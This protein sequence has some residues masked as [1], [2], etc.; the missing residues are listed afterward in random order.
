MLRALTASV[1]FSL[2]LAAPALAQQAEPVGEAW[3]LSVGEGLQ[4]SAD[5]RPSYLAGRPIV[6]TL[7]VD[8]AGEE[9]LEF[10]RLDERP[11]LVSFEL[12]SAAGKKQT[13][14]NAA[15]VEDDDL[16][17]SLP[18]RASR[19]VSL[20]L[21]SGGALAPGSYQL[22]IEVE[23]DEVHRL[24]PHALIIEAPRPVSADVTEAGASTLGWQVPWVHASDGHDLYLHTASAGDPSAR[25]YEWHLHGLD[26]PVQPLLAHGPGLE[27]AN[28]MIYWRD[29]ERS[30]AF[31]RLEERKLRHD[32]RTVTL[33]YPD[34][35]LLARAGADGQGGLQVPVWIPAPSGEA[36]E[37]RVVSID[38]R[39]QPRF[40]RVE[41]FDLAPVA[42]S[43]VDNAGRLRLLLHHDEKLDLYTV[44][45]TGELPA[46]G[47]RLLPQALR[48][49]EVHLLARPTPPE[50]SPA[51]GALVSDLIL[52][53]VD[54][55]LAAMTPPS[56]AGVRF[57]PLPERG[58]EAGGMA[59]FTW[60]GAT[61][62]GEMPGVWLSIKG[63][64]IDTVPG[65]AL[66]PGHVVVE[67]FPQGYQPYILL[68]EDAKGQR[69]LH[70]AR[71]QAPVP[72]GRMGP[73]DGLRVDERG[74][75]W[76]V[77]LED[78]R[79]VVVTKVVEP[80]EP[81]EPDAGEET[82]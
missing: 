42:D 16:R 40:R 25:G 69:W 48:A 27:G 26:G 46:V 55:R 1:A 82:P 15:P 11:H 23:G 71:W 72:L 29:G 2:L 28:R 66:P 49:G 39:G 77:G 24:G 34:W 4:I 21:P 45:T 3:T 65:V 7:R 9:T 75:V 79:G 37:V 5:A 73:N 62:A 59:V 19:Q 57:G 63:R 35:R 56:V 18:P 13:R 67:V 60:L 8:N 41:A 81:V 14:S 76:R 68:S 31:A 38:P 52:G 58:E 43:W 74:A 36:G 44:D 12:V 70:S 33:P 30:I 32:P 10:P 53:F 50:R 17:W 61:P 20:E 80:P 78:G 51:S 22:A 54:E 6:I 47:V 64:V